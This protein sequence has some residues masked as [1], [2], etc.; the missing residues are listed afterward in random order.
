MKTKKSVFDLA[1]TINTIKRHIPTFDIKTIIEHES[2]DNYVVEVNDALMFRFP[3]TQ[4]TTD[5]VAGEAAL[6]ELLRPKVSLQIPRLFYSHETFVSY[7]K[8]AGQALTFELYHKLDGQEKNRLALD[9]ATFFYQVHKSLDVGYARMSGVQDAEWPLSC[10]I[11]IEK[12][13]KK[14]PDKRLEKLFTHMRAWR[15]SFIVSPDDI[16]VVH[17]DVHEKNIAFDTNINR[18]NGIFDFSDRAIGDRYLEFRYLYLISPELMENAAQEYAR[19]VG[20]NFN[21]QRV[22]YYYVATE[23]SRLTECVLG[24]CWMQDSEQ[25]TRRLLEMSV[26]F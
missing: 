6:L 2:C 5:R 24:S 17:N 4:D 1:T 8:I 11:L 9:F 14:L 23:F 19:L 12:L 16:V 25:I 21:M 3:K 13:G 18:I 20:Q 7:H 26:K 22:L 10:E 15:D